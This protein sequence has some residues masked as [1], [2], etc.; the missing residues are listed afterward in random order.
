MFD[1]ETVIDRQEVG[2]PAP[3][4]MELPDLVDIQSSSYERF[5]QRKRM[6]QG[7]APLEQGLQDVFT[8]TF[9]I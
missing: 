4:V 9:P 6:L 5:L 3:R 2:K 1:R 8:Q 7:E